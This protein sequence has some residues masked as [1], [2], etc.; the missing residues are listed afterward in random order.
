MSV[1]ASNQTPMASPVDGPRAAW[2]S[3]RGALQSIAP[4]ALRLALAIPFFRSGLTKW[5][6]FLALSPSATYLFENE[7]KL[8]IF[9]GV[10]ALPFPETMAMLSGIGEIVFPIMLVLGLGT[11]FA[12]LGVLAM[13]AVIQL[14]YPTHWVSEGLP[15]AAMALALIAFGAGAISIDRLVYR[16]M[17]R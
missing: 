11:R 5:D 16:A 9:G 10:Y 6:G 17:K 3:A 15:W 13:A 14:A 7:F 12:A 2:A 8:H 1:H 4:L